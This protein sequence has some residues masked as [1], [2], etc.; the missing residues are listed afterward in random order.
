MALELLFQF[1]VLGIAVGTLSGLLGIGGGG[2]MVPTLTVMFLAQGVTDTNVVHLALG[3]SMSA[4]IVT[5]VA[6]FMA[7]H[8]RSGVLWP[9]VKAMSP[10]IVIGAFG[11]TFLVAQLP[12]LYLT[13]FF[14][15]FMAFVALQMFRNVVPDAEQTLPGNAGL[16]SVGFG[17]GS[18]SSLVSIG[19]GSLTVPFLSWRN[20][21]MAKAIGTSAAVGFPISVAGSIGYLI[22]GLHS[23]TEL[24]Y[25][26]GYVY[27]PG[28]IIIS[29]CSVV[30]APLGAKLAHT[31]PVKL[32]KKIFSLLLVALS[33]KMLMTIL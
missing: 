4:I 5:S 10:G 27:L 12:A 33:V 9:V 17:I 2:I 25:S 19:G 22:N 6:S 30:F 31:L 3:T 24:E 26:L 18:I 11:A 23:T 7:H 14:S 29:L 20:I 1:I 13:L 21:P 16:F 32:L 28:V 8:K 15:V